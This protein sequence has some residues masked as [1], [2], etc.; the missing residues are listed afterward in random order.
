V[1]CGGHVLEWEADDSG[2]HVRTD[3]DGY[4]ASRLVV[5]VGESVLKNTGL[6][7]S[8]TIGIMQCLP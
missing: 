1:H 2:V 7:T 8:F 3:R 5:I 4:R 6:L